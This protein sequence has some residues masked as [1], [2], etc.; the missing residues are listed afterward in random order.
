[1]SAMSSASIATSPRRSAKPQLPCRVNA[2]L[3]S[4]GAIGAGCAS[5]H[6]TSRR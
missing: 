6:V 2:S 4:I 1:M 5:S 3:P